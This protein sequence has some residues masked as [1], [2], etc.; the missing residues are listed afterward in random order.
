MSRS[1]LCSEISVKI[2]DDCLFC[3]CRV[4]SCVQG[5][6]MIDDCLFCR[7]RGHCCVEGVLLR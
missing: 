7:C 1:F 3:R 2:I 5:V 6:R 4:V